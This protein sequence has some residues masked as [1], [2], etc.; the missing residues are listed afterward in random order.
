MNPSLLSPLTLLLVLL[1][2]ATGEAK[3]YSNALVNCMKNSTNIQPDYFKVTFD[4]SDRSL[5][6]DVSLSANI[7][8]KLTAHATVYAFGFS[9][10]K[11]SFDLCSLGLKQF[12]P[13][14]ASKIEVESI[15]YIDKEYVDMIPGIAYTFP[16]IDAVARLIL[17]DENNQLLGCLQ[18]TINNGKTISHE[19]AKWAT[20][21][22][23]GLGLL[24]SAGLSLYGN[25]AAASRMSAFAISLFTYF[26]SVVIISMISVE[27]AP[28][29]ASS[30]SE[31]LAW[32]MGIIRIEFMQKIFRW[33]IQATGGIPTQYLTTSAKQ[34]LTQRSHNDPVLKPSSI[35]G[36]ISNF[37]FPYVNG[38]EI[39][40]R[41]NIHDFFIGLQGVQ[42]N[43]YLNVLRGM[44][45]VSYGANVEPTSLVC[46][47][48]TF[49]IFFLY[50][51]IGLYFV[52]R[53]F[54]KILRN[55]ATTKVN[56]HLNDD[57]AW[58]PVFKGLLARY[59]YIAF[60]QLTIFSL[61]E[62][63]RDDSA[64]I[65][66]LSVFFFILGM[67]TMIFCTYKV[68]Y[69]ARL[70]IK[71]TGNPAAY[72]YGDEKVL[73]RYG[74][75][76]TMLDARK[77]WFCGVMLFYTFVKA[78]FVSLAQHSGK[79]QAMALWIIDMIYLGVLIHFMPYL[80]RLTNILS[81][82][83]AVVVTIN[84][85]FFTFF[86]N[87]YGQQS[88]VA[89]VMGIIFFILNAAVSLILLIMILALAIITV[90][91]KNP[92]A[93]FSPTKDD[94]TSF[95]KGH[96]IAMD[97]TNE[98]FH[99][100]LVAKEHDP[101]WRNTIY[102]NSDSK[103]IIEDEDSDLQ[104]K[105][106]GSSSKL[107]KAWGKLSRGLSQKKINSP[108][109]VDEYEEQQL[110]VTPNELDNE[111]YHDDYEQPIQ[112]SYD[113]G[114]YSYDEL[115]P[116]GIGHHITSPSMDS[117]ALDPNNPFKPIQHKR[118]SMG[119]SSDPFGESKN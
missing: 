36:S 33:Y 85:F 92:D 10:I 28:P 4:P 39:E 89:P 91:F 109:K 1:F 79:T 117:G 73:N 54:I 16:N 64:G 40:K 47:S 53:G 31:N 84:S 52:F 8:G 115:P 15:Q 116:R 78:L 113:N 51:L 104:R 5:N 23:A 61:F 80:D 32:S 119:S 29:I 22:V 70:S 101:N 106:S 87:I 45:R 14:T 19:G 37:F 107:G 13:L 30:W 35:L 76:Y 38:G 34:I 24:I 59:L 83:I 68:F 2:A 9:V 25:S 112:D 58:S 3:L 99:L 21:V 96:S 6:Y 60:P 44:D 20:A 17:V 71:E 100:G 43:N 41:A 49:F 18:A 55:K 42:S 12:C 94:R 57:K 26:Q 105:L 108:Q 86:S 93:K 103:D 63:T 82:F 102:G 56:I 95:Q 110:S 98:L 90:F 50:L 118:F 67:S 69:H 88:S 74:F 111:Q 77:Y 81:I 97:E 11:K 46:T 27:A 48:F 66:T 62:F 7:E 65:L 75:L 72:L 114:E